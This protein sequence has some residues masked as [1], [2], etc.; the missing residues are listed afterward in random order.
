MAG[1][2]TLLFHPNSSKPR[3][4]YPAGFFSSPPVFP[5]WGRHLKTELF[6][7]IHRTNSNTL[8]TNL[9]MNT[10]ASKLIA[11]SLVLLLALPSGWCCADTLIGHTQTTT[12]VSNCCQQSQSPTPANNSDDGQ[13]T[14]QCPRGVCCCDAEW[15]VEKPTT[16]PTP[17]PVL[18]ALVGLPIDDTTSPSSAIA[19]PSQLTDA[20]PRLYLLQCVWRI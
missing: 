8:R 13:R 20:S 19:L 3:R 16:D 14:P 9:Y 12:P 18:S 11:S 1:K 17:R 2:Q 4:V 15:A 5:S 10:F 6:F 7:E